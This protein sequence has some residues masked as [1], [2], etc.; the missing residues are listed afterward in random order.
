MLEISPER[1]D[2]LLKKQK[3][4][5][6]AGKTRGL[7]VRLAALER[8]ET[9]FVEKKEELLEALQTDL[10]KPALEAFLAEYHFLL[11]EVRLLRKSLKQWL[12]PRRAKSPFYFWPCRNEVRLEPHGQVLIIAPWNCPVQLALAPLLSA[13]AAGNTVILKPSEEVPACETFL[14]KL[15]AECFDSEWVTV[16]TGGAKFTSS[17]LDLRFDF[18]FFTGSTRVGKIVAQK[19][20]RHLTPAILELGGKCPCVVDASVDLEETAKRILIGKLFNAGQTCFAPDFVAVDN[21]IEEALVEE[22]QRVLS[23]FPWEEEMARIVNGRHYQRLRA[24]CQEGDFRKGDDGP[25]VLHLAPRIV[26]GGTWSDSLM[27]EE[28]FGP[29]LPV[30]GYA[31]REDLL[32][33]L[34]HLPVPLALYCFSTNEAF[35][36]DLTMRVPSGGVC[37][38]DVAKQGSNLEMSFG[39]KGESGYGRYRGQRSVEAFSYERAYTKRFLWFDPFESIPPRGKQARFLQKWMK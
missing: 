30:V 1:L 24:L 31:D 10:G 28:I 13:V 14:E 5:F 25:N 9:I 32:E 27:Q 19:A 8:F 6:E 26:S 17:L 12:R 16:V 11:Q 23:A 18:L 3:A 39:G 22:L 7:E 36:D 29:I 21:Q 37:V 4:F 2:E 15:I 20:A 35:V 38:N 34:S 33:K